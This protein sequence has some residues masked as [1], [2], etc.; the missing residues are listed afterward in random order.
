MPPDVGG[1][2][3]ASP[4]KVGAVIIATRLIA[5]A[6]SLLPDEIPTLPSDHPVFF[7]VNN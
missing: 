2:S 3:F 1:F 6:A 7:G 5:L 4:D